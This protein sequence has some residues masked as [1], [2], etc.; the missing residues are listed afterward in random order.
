[1][2][3]LN[4]CRHRGVVEA[5][6]GAEHHSRRRRVKQQPVVDR[7]FLCSISAEM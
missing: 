5:Q 4:S 7:K 1:M 2:H 3:N 6:A